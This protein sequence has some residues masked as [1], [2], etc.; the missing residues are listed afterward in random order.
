MWKISVIAVVY[1]LVASVIGLVVNLPGYIMAFKS[2]FNA[3][4][5]DHTSHGSPIWM[6]LLSQF[7]GI[8]SSA[9]THP[10]GSIG[11]ILLYYDIRIRFEGFDIQMLAQAVRQTK[12][13]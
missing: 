10:I 2:V 4:S 8:L 6:V 5:G 13:K 9:A 11:F 1:L 3:A 7:L 12:S